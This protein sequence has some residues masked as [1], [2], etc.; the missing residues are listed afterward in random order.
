MLLCNAGSSNTTHEVSREK[1]TGV[2]L[3]PVYFI[4]CV[5]STTYN[6]GK[7]QW[8]DIVVTAFINGSHKGLSVVGIVSSL[9]IQ[10]KESN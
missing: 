7:I 2:R 8:N 6:L 5:D 10:P 9:D 1:I 3:L 4:S